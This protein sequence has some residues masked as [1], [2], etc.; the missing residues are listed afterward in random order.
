MTLHI[1]LDLQACQTP[2]SRQRGI[3]RYSLALAQ[4]L[5]QV[6]DGQRISVLLSERFP[7]TLT[8][9]RQQL[10]EFMDQSDI[11][12][13]AV[14]PDSQMT[15]ARRQA[16][17]LLYQRRVDQ[18]R[19]D[20]LHIASLFENEGGEAVVSVDRGER[21]RHS[22]ATFY[23]LIPFLYSEHYLRHE[24]VRSA[25]YRQLQRV[26]RTDVLLAISESSRQ[27][28]LVH[29]GML[30]SQVVNIAAAVADIFRPLTLASDAIRALRQRYSLV[31]EFILYTGGMDH[32]KNITGLIEAYAQLDAALR[33]AYQLVIVC[34]LQPE[35]RRELLRHAQQCGVPTTDL[36]LTGYVPDDDLVALYNLAGL[37]VFPSLHEGFGLPILEAM[38][39]GT[40]AIA[41]NTSSMPEVLGRADALFDPHD[42]TAI[43][44]AIGAVLCDPERQQVLRAHGLQ[45]AQRFSWQA[46]ARK[47]LAAYQTLPPLAASVSVPVVWPQRPR[48]AYVSPL[49]P[50][51]SGIADYSAQLLPELARYYEIELISTVPTLHD[52]WLQA[53]FPLRSMAELAECG[54][55]YARILYHLGNSDFHAPMFPLL[56]RYPGVVMLHDAFLSGVLALGDSLH[57]EPA[58]F[59]RSLF[60]AHGYR[61]LRDLFSEDL[62]TVVR[63]YP[64]SRALLDFALGVL[65]HSRHAVELLAGF[66]GAQWA[67]RVTPIPFPKAVAPQEPQRRAAARQRLGVEAEAYIVASFGFLAPVKRSLDL[68]QA[69]QASAVAAQPQAQ[70]VFV[71]ALAA[72][73]DYAQLLR[74][75]AAQAGIRI[76]GYVDVAQYQDWLLAADAAVQLRTDSR[77]ETSAA[78]FD[79]LAYGL[80]TVYNAHGSAAELPA[81]VGWRLAAAATVA[82]ITAAL[83]GM[84]QDAALRARLGGAAREYLATAHQP[85]QVARAY[86]Q[87]IESC[88]QQAPLAA[89]QRLVQRLAVLQPD[90]E[91]RTLL[92]QCIARQRAVE[93]APRL[94][95]D[96]SQCRQWPTAAI[97]ALLEQLPP[98]LDWDVV[99]R[100]PTGQWSTN[101]HGVCQQFAWPEVLTEDSPVIWGSQDYWLVIAGAAQAPDPVLWRVMTLPADPSAHDIA[102]VLGWARGVHPTD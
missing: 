74:T 94:W 59:H 36:V 89:E 71:G 13:L 30:P 79:A 70:L 69:W 92:S 101:R 87:A 1:L 91:Q 16:A 29:L 10:G 75:Q 34:S 56:R 18:L 7:D 84:Y 11:H 72:G 82:E 42:N 77:G 26:K 83:E 3:G 43:A 28:A 66:H 102:C 41:A 14:P 12:T 65:V 24:A 86:Y 61:A 39:C 68:M 2:E 96:I 33:A 20:I 51:R 27:E 6:A 81:S 9:L 100:L 45:Q 88:Y 57:L 22:A 55:D 40:P 25:Y 97:A 76:T 38:A 44:A 5:L 49:P 48:L 95:V 32:R 54:E 63:R 98:H 4:G 15:P 53:N 64:A 35:E 80:P 23:D 17:E 19:P 47:A 58:L 90:A 73:D 67:Q 78:V 37:F 52:P 21:P 8:P 31:R 60:R 46:S 50:Q 93:R 62:A 85:A 99:Q